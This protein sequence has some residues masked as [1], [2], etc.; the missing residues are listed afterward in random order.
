MTHVNVRTKSFLKEFIKSVRFFLRSDD[1][2]DFNL[3][4]KKIQKENVKIEI[5]K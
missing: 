4:R 5:N 3:S 1:L 2:N